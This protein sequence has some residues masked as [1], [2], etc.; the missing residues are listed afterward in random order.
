M[1]LIKREEWDREWERHTHWQAEQG[2]SA[3]SGKRVWEREREREGR[4]GGSERGKGKERRREEKR[5]ETSG[6]ER[7]QQTEKHALKESSEWRRHFLLDPQSA[8]TQFIYSLLSACACLSVSDL[9]WVATCKLLS[10]T[11][12]R[13]HLLVFALCIS[14]QT[15]HSLHATPKHQTNHR[16]IALESFI[17]HS[18]SA[19]SRPRSQSSIP[20]HF[21]DKPWNFLGSYSRPWQQDSQLTL[22]AQ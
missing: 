16:N 13:R 20:P 17:P 5:K 11:S 12:S 14:C 7:E 15:Q 9:E 21:D 22:G 1:N 19:L 10:P 6:R 3:G 2:T 4:R 18:T 8:H